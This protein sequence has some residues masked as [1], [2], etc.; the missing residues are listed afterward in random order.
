M[1]TKHQFS[2]KFL[3]FEMF[4]AGCAFALMREGIDRGGETGT[5]LTIA[6][7]LLIGTATGGLFGS[8]AGGLGLSLAVLL[9]IGF[10]VSV[11]GPLGFLIGLG[12]V[13]LVAMALQGDRSIAAQRDEAF[14]RQQIC[15]HCSA[16]AID[17][18]LESD[19]DL[20]NGPPMRAGRCRRC[21]QQSLFR[22][23]EPGPT[24]FTKTL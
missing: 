5:L 22:L 15:P 17:P 19:V 6:S 9:S 23:S 21:G 8:F 14:F 11:F 12:F 18:V 4:L 24:G 1:F 7:I 2:I 16:V 3:L 13:F 10:F 20:M